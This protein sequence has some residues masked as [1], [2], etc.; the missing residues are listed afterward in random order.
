[1]PG[2]EEGVIGSRDQNITK[3]ENETPYF[4]G[5]V[6]RTQRGEKKREPFLVREQSPIR[7]TCD[8]G[9]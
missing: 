8:F 1:L 6:R 4:Q 3:Q 2:E 5:N 7:D 9:S